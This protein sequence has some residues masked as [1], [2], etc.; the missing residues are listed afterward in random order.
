MKLLINTVSTLLV[1]AFMGVFIY[2]MTAIAG[3]SFVNNSIIAILVWVAMLAVKV[4]D[5]E[6][7]GDE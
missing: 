3:G 5:L 6:T 4:M 1:T 2:G 7:K